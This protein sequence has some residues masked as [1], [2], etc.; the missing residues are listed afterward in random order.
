[1]NPRPP[2][3]V[4]RADIVPFW[5]RLPSFFRLPFAVDKLLYLLLLSIG[6]LVAFVLPVPSPLDIIIVEG[7]IWLTAWRHSFRTME[8]MA[9]G[10]VDP[11]AQANMILDDPERVNLPWNMV[12]LLFCWGLVTAVV[13]SISPALGTL[14]SLFVSVAMPAMAM[15]L[16]ASN[17]FSESMSPARWWHFIRSIGAPYL[18]LCLFLLLLTNGGPQALAM[19]LPLLGGWLTL[20]IVNFVML[21]F[22][23]I[24]FAMMGYVMYQYHDALGLAVD[25]EPAGE[26]EAEP[27]I[28]GKIAG[29]LAAGKIAEAVELAE[30]VARNERTNLAA[31]ERLHKL[32]QAAGMSEKLRQHRKRFFELA[33]RLGSATRA[34]ALYRE[35]AAAG[36]P[37]V[38]SAEQVL[39][40]AQAADKERDTKLAIELVRAFDKRFPGHANIPDIYFFSARVASERL[41]KDDLARGMLQELLRR[42][43]GHALAPEA[44]RYLEVIDRLAAP[45]GAG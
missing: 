20:P 45:K 43:P 9:H 14:V 5:E 30:D 31:S 29:L 12:G 21:Y 33:L 6:S 13:G 32:L 10:H 38:L 3:S 15:Q 25:V 7:V 36:E 2:A 42:Y 40:L 26:A 24:V 18:V 17:D 11:E 41:R 34:L 35:L 1:M 23:L 28:D 44:T 4:R 16:C 22:N 27:G 19:L 37:P 8:L 39:P